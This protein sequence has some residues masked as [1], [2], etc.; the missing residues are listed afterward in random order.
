VT[1][2]STVY[3]SPT[4]K[5]VGSSFSRVTVG[6]LAAVAEATPNSKVTV[7]TRMQIAADLFIADLPARFE[8]ALPTFYQIRAAMSN[9][10]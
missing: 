5:W 10:T 3:D 1:W 6:A 9:G 8:T 2:I 7:N 4:A